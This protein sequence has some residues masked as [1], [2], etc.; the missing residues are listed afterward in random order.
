MKREKIPTNE[1]ERLLASCNMKTLPEDISPIHHKVIQDFLNKEVDRRREYHL[2]RLFAQ[3]GISQKETRT[4]DSFNW[5]FNPKIKKEEIISFREG[6]WI[7]EP[8]N[9]VL[10]GDAG[11]GKTHIAK[12]LCYD[13]ILKGY[14]THF[15]TLFSLITKI[16][17]ATNIPKKIDYFGTKIKVLCIDELGYS[18]Y[19]KDDADLLYHVISK[20]AEI[21]PTIVTTNLPPAKWG[22]ILSGSAATAILDRLSYK[23]KFITFEGSS[24]RLNLKKK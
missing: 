6:D 18:F 21:L 23:G 3:S 4:F 19:A 8:S 15:S 22:S 11:V 20:R 7:E 17:R 9:L 13:A 2:K 12:S 16:K 1:M 10:I 24:Y 14:E 5:D